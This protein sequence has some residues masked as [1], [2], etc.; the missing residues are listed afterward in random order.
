MTKPSPNFHY[1]HDI[2]LATTPIVEVWLTIHWELEAGDHPALKKDPNFDLALGRFADSV[3]ERFGIPKENPASQIP[4]DMIP[5]QVRYQFRP[6][7]DGFPLLQLGPGVASVNFTQEYT[8]KNFRETA[9]YLRTRL[10]DVYGEDTL[11]TESISLQYRN[12]IPFEYSSGD[13]ARFLGS[14]LNTNIRAPEF[15]PGNA[16]TT[17]N[18][19]GM[20]LL[21][22][23]EL[24]EPKGI[25]V[26]KIATGIKK[27]ENTDTDPEHLIVEIEVRSKKD[28]APTLSDEH[29][30]DDWL[31]AANR[32][33]HEWFLSLIDGNLRQKYE[34]GEE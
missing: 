6:S 26:L 4:S 2:K 12:A 20:N 24:Q 25:G 31:V 19:L 21:L 32:V 9:L 23:Y 1:D 17:G 14:D 3:K 30:F 16:A 29:H 10:V 11:K 18:I 8:W 7:E 22:S 13:L 5:Y 15:I 28:D 34:K 27:V 33:A